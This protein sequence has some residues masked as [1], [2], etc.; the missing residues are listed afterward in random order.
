MEDRL[1]LLSRFDVD[2]GRWRPMFYGVKISVGLNDGDIGRGV[3]EL[4]NQPFIMTRITHQLVGQYFIEESAN[5][6]NQ[7]G[8]YEIEW[9]DDYNTY[10]NDAIMAELMFGITRLGYTLDL[11]FPIPYSGNKGLTFTITNRFLR[12]PTAEVE[13]IVVGICVAGVADF[14]EVAGVR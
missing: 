6:A 10:Q 14:G 11:P 2:P 12:V 4:N 1:P 5:Q 9:K 3:I 13:K 7:D 8:Q